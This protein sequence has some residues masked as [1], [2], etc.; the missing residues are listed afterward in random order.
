MNNLVK[1]GLVKRVLYQENL[2]VEKKDYF[3]FPRK[4]YNANS[5]SKSQH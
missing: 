2:T 4:K 5:E 1:K 3:V